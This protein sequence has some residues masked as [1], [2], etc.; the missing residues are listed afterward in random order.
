[1]AWYNYVACFFAGA[2]LCNFV[3]HFIK[4]VAG[5]KFPTPFANP[6]AK[7]LS[8]PYLNVLWALFN[9]VI[10]MV[11]ISVGKVSVDNTLSLVVMFL[12]FAIVSV[13]LSLAAETKHTT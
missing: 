1:M 13:F 2:L 5:D 8:R 6:P 12:G 4:G 9:L 3:P 10:S 7:G 11:L